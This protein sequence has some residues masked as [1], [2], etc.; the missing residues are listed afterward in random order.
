M[1]PQAFTC[2]FG[3]LQYLVATIQATRIQTGHAPDINSFQI[4]L[5]WE[6]L[7]QIFYSTRGPQRIY[8]V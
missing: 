2:M 4:Q 8:L 5:L 1:R 3:M 6:K 7:F